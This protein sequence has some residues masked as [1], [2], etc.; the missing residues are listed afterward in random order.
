MQRIGL[1][2]RRK[3]LI[4][5]KFRCRGWRL[6]QRKVSYFDRDGDVRERCSK[7]QANP[8]HQYRKIKSVVRR[9]W[10]RWRPSPFLRTLNSPAMPHQMLLL[11]R[12]RV[13]RAKVS[14]SR[15]ETE[16]EPK[17]ARSLP[18]KLRARAPPLRV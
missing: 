14:S 1:L 17:L 3:P 18:S 11:S 13:P 16:V 2:S 7:R 12:T 9:N 5:N 4:C 8:I 10:S 6:D 15:P